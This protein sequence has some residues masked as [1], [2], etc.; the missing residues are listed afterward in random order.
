MEN[1]MI[2]HS[3]DARKMEDT[4]NIPETEPQTEA[5]SSMDYLNP[6][7]PTDMSDVVSYWFLGGL[8][9]TLCENTKYKL[10]TANIQMILT[11]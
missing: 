1:N 11:L 2:W 9:H 3:A 4:W 6:R 5:K 10:K 7:K 8:L